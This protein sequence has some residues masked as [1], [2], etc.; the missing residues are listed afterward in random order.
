MTTAR[1]QTSASTPQSWVTST[2]GHVPPV[3]QL[4]QQ[5]QD[6]RLHGDV[7]GGGRLVGDQQRRIA[8]QR[9]RDRDALGHAAGQ[10]GRVQPGD[11]LGLG[12]L[13]GR[14]Q[15][16][17]PRPGR[18]PADPLVPPDHLGELAADPE[19]PGR[20]RTAA[21]ARPARS[22]SRGPGP[23][24]ARSAR[25]ARCRRRRPAPATTCP[26]GGSRPSRLRAVTRLARAGLADDADASR[27]AATSKLT[28]RTAVAS[29]CGRSNATVRPRTDSSAAAPGAGFAPA[30]PVHPAA[31]AR[32]TRAGSG[33]PWHPAARPR[34]GRAPAR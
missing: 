2:I 1:S 13:H 20:G 11:P 9:Q 34:T 15:L 18:R 3:A 29:P 4:A 33:R 5:G 25:S 24:R 26:L 16:D 17:R 19:R 8:G 30:R 21:P 23:A 27:P 14:Q 28:S 12:D 22:G 31:G 7:Q 32:R 6:L 10:L